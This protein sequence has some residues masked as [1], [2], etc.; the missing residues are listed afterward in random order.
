MGT[1]ANN[2]VSGFPSEGPHE[3]ASA[4][5][6]DE[7][8][9]TENPPDGELKTENPPDRDLKTESPQDEAPDEAF[10]RPPD[11]A[12]R[13]LE[14]GRCQSAERRLDSGQQ[15]TPPLKKRIR[16][17]PRQRNRQAGQRHAH[18]GVQPSFSSLTSG[19]VE[20]GMGFPKSLCEQK[21]P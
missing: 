21:Y 18:S 17:G 4:N 19:G 5:P 15:D 11:E 6:P 8:L 16:K 20:H 14:G 13:L 2:P 7:E 10:E 9:V 1:K 3:E 12:P